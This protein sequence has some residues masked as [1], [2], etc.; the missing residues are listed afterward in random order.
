MEKE[1]GNAMIKFEMLLFVTN[2]TDQILTLII[3]RPLLSSLDYFRIYNV[4]RKSCLVT[5]IVI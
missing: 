1:A 2:K 3:L 4:E 5:V